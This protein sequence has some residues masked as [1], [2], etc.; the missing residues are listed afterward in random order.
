MYVRCFKSLN[1]SS[2]KDIC[3]VIVVACFYLFVNYL[4]TLSV[5]A[6][7]HSYVLDIVCP[8][9]MIPATNLITDCFFGTRMKK[10]S[11]L[12]FYMFLCGII[13]EYF[14]PKESAVTDIFDIVCY[15]FGTL[16]YW[17]FMRK[18][19]FKSKNKD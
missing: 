4:K 2:K 6:F 13:F 17:L 10:L 9:G 7:L 5:N 18:Y 15:L 12:M 8:I 19:L 11:I 14:N 3:V 1:N 16:L